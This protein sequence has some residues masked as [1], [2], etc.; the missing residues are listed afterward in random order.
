MLVINQLTVGLK[1]EESILT[2]ISMVIEKQQIIALLGKNGAGKTTLMETIMS[3]HQEFT[4]EL[5]FEECPLTKKMIQKKFGYMEADPFFYH[6]LT[7]FEML[8]YLC[9]VRGIK[10]YETLIAKWLHKVNLENK[11]NATIKSLSKGMKQ[12]LSFVMSILHKPEILLLDEPFNAL[13]PEEIENLKQ[14]ILDFSQNSGILI[15]THVFSFIQDLATDVIFIHQGKV[16]ERV[17][18]AGE[19]WTLADY[20][21]NFKAM[22]G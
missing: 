10:N 20:E 9:L 11:K 1:G 4:G 8:E 2:D 15:S 7:V 16:K 3:L 22:H 18:V 14:L 12:R 6:Y 5:L 17:N 19:K 13:D 21:K